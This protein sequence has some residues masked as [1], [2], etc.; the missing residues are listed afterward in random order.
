MRFFLATVSSGLLIMDLNLQPDFCKAALSAMS[1]NQECY[2]PIRH[3]I[4][5]TFMYM[6]EAED[7]NAGRRFECTKHK[8]IQVRAKQDENF[9]VVFPDYGA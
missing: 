7:P 6:D 1:V 8:V 9:A 2:T 4:K 5:P 3:N